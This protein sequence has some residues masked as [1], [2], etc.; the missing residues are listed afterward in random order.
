MPSLWAFSDKYVSDK[1]KTLRIAYVDTDNYPS[2]RA[3]MRAGYPVVGYAGF[4]Y[5]FGKLFSFRTPGAKEYG[6]RLFTP[7]SPAVENLKPHPSSQ[8]FSL[9]E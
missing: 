6:F 4:I 8:G 3:G 9:P 5:L 7:S 2:L 1:G